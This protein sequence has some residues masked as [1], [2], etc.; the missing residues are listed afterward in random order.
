MGRFISVD[1]LIDVS[2]PQQMQG[3]S[4]AGNNPVS[5]SDPDGRIM[6]MDAESGGGQG[7]YTPTNIGG[8]G[9]G[10]GNYQPG[11]HQQDKCEHSWWCKIKKRA[12]DHKADIAAVAV[13]VVVGVG[14]DAAIG[15]T[16]VGAIGC[17]ALADAAGSITHDLVEGG[18]SVAEMAGNAVFS[19]VIGGVTTGVM[20]VGG[21]ALSA[22][23][24]SL[25]TG[26]G[27]QAARQAASG[28]ARRR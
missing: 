1:P 25:V 26:E 7:Y 22:G 28:A 24:R 17:G 13:G 4:Y 20:S 27:A 18:H 10:G 9:G 6:R 2:D 11:D 21:Q 3:Y 19:G 14:C 23:V 15:W 12:S 16:G 5:F 8:G